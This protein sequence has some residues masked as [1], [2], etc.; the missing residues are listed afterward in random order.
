[1]DVLFAL[2]SLAAVGALVWVGTQ[3]KEIRTQLK[4]IRDDTRQLVDI[5]F[6]VIGTDDLTDDS[7]RHL[8]PA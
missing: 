6:N 3:L 2:W 4:E 7:T 8:G 5:N 1:M